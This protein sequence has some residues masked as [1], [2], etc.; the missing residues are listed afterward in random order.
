MA[1]RAIEPLIEPLGFNWKIGIGLVSSLLQREVFVS[2]MG[3]IYNIENNGDHDWTLSLQRHM[4]T[5]VNAETGHPSFNPL[6]VVCLLVYYVLAMQCLSTVAVVR[7]ETGGWKWPT[8]QI[9]YM[10]ALA[11]GITFVVHLTGTWLGWGGG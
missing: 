1:G 2:T 11:Y 8:V 5:D 9:A 3:T 4:Q 7:R 6:T 10:T